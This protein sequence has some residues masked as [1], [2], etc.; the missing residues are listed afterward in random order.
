MSN[1]TLEA[2]RARCDEVADCWIWRDGTTADGY[3]IF[4]P[5]GQRKCVLVRRYVFE[6]A[7]G[8]LRP[9]VPVVAKCGERKC[10]NP[11]C[12]KE[13]TTAKIAQEAGKRG[14]YSALSKRAKVAKLKRKTGKLDMEKAAEIRASGETSRA[15]GAKYGVN[16]TLISRIK[17]GLQWQDYSN[18]W[19]GLAA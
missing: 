7:G 18:P 9:R 15:L 5:T 13:S 17:R 10:V 12:A 19:Q 11:A 14:S 16:P 6:L 3:P 4:K 8:K 1:N 2:I